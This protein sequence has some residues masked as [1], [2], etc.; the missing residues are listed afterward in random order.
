MSCIKEDQ[1]VGR[2][3]THFLMSQESNRKLRADSFDIT[4]IM[5][6]FLAIKLKT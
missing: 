2:E 4:V 5:N 1:R 3:I 6:T